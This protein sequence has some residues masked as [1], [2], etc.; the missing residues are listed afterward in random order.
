MINN[1]NENV[2][3]SLLGDKS[4]DQ[5]LGSNYLDSFKP[6]HKEIVAPESTLDIIQKKELK[7]LETKNIKNSNKNEAVKNIRKRKEEKAKVMQDIAEL[8]PEEKLEINEIVAQELK[9]VS[10]ISI[11]DDVNV[12][13]AELD[14]NNALEDIPVGKNENKLLDNIEIK[15][16]TSAPKSKDGY[17]KHTVTFKKEGI[18]QQINYIS[19][20][21]KKQS[22]GIVIPRITDLRTIANT[23]KTQ[24]RNFNIKLGPITITYRPKAG[25]MKA[26]KGTRVMVSLPENYESTGDLIIYM[27]E[28]RSKNILILNSKEFESVEHFNQFIGDRI[29]EYFIVGYD[30]AV[31]KL[32]LRTV[33]NPLMGLIDEIVKTHEFKARPYVDKDNHLYGVDFVARDTPQ[34]EWLY[35]NVMEADLA[36]TYIVK[37]KMFDGD[38]EL[39]LAMS[40]RKSRTY[41]LEQLRSKLYIS[42]VNGYKKDWSNELGTNDKS[43]VGRSRLIDKWFS[44]L[45]IRTVKNAFISLLEIEEGE[46]PV[47]L[48]IDSVIGERQFKLEN[49]NLKGESIM[50]HT[51]YTSFKLSYYLMPLPGKDSRDSKSFITSEKYYSMT[52]VK[53]RQEY[54]DRRNT[55]FK[56]EGKNR[57][58]N[59]GANVFEL[60]YT[61]KGTDHVYIAKTLDDI[62]DDTQFLTDHVKFPKSKF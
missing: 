34:N 62:I 26:N 56:K 3:D 12:I 31:K 21:I 45:K 42:M 10:D 41:T 55:V 43:D 27:Q 33:N 18:P 50:G 13:E 36:G 6:R 25:K 35:F 7:E 29:A 17:Y 23:N 53:T 22:K 61:H 48:K 24:L 39:E 49:D 40:E 47:N 16:V 46:N 9:V 44:S 32:Q 5:N 54:Q 14:I 38:Y 19:S 60:Q 52:G 59:T 11:A 28:S 37:A 2:F 4:Q 57:K 8:N 1:L 15:A 51:D 20:Y 30:I 58:Y